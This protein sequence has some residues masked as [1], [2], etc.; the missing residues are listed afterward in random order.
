MSRDSVDYVIKAVAMVA[1]HGWKLLPQVSMLTLHWGRQ[2]WEIGNKQLQLYILVLLY[3]YWTRKIAVLCVLD[4]TCQP[5]PTFFLMHTQYLF[6]PETGM[7]RHHK[8]HLSRD[9]CWLSS[10]SYDSGEMVY[11]Q[12]TKNPP[13]SF[14]V[15]FLVSAY[16]CQW[17]RWSWRAILCQSGNAVSSWESIWT[18]ISVQGEVMS[19]C[20]STSIAASVSF[21]LSI[22]ARLSFPTLGWS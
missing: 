18:S 13:P 3:C 22:I 11:T 9:R 17:L 21:Y 20:M 19:M 12:S 1:K 6:N 14:E 5:L 8:H 16:H 15:G 10:I 7:F 2:K 4:G